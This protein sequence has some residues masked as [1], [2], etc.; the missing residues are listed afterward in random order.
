VICSEKKVPVK[1]SPGNIRLVFGINAIA[2]LPVLKMKLRMPLN[3]M[4]NL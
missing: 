3:G 2:R 4:K 1:G